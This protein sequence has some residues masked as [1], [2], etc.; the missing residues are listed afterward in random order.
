MTT[1][2]ILEM[3]VAH[4]SEDKANHIKIATNEMKAGHYD[5]AFQ[6]L[7]YAEGIAYCANYLSHLHQLSG[8]EEAE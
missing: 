2:E 3:A 4:L 1:K 8:K 7:A 6:Q 5:Q